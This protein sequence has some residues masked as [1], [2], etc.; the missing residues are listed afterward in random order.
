M[1]DS[2]AWLDGANLGCLVG[3]E[4]E[5]AVALIASAEPAS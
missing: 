4:P 2:I 1:S 5:R 3:E